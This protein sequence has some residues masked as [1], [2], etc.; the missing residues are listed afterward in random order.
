MGKSAG[1]RRRV[2]SWAGQREA[3]PRAPVS[4]KDQAGRGLGGTGVRTRAPYLLSSLDVSDG[5]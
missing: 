4:G 1:L 5:A 2:L 3:V